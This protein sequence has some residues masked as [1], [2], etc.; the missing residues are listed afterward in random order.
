MYYFLIISICIVIYLSFRYRKLIISTLKENSF[1]KNIIINLFNLIITIY[2]Y[3][4][5]WYKNFYDNY[6]KELMKKNKIY[7]YYIINQDDILTKS[8]SSDNYDYEVINKNENELII[9]E[10]IDNE[11]TYLYA[12]L[13]E[14]KNPHINLI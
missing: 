12:N 7:N 14:K 13:F 1:L 9:K 5:I 2:T 10:I 8:F 11:K 3:L 6:L 4:Q